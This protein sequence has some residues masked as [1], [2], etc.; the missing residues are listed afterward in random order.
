MLQQ[1]QFGPFHLSY[2]SE[3]DSVILKDREEAFSCFGSDQ[4]AVLPGDAIAK[5]G[6]RACTALT[7]DQR[8]AVDRSIP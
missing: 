7:R 8:R 1:Y 4:A 6:L 2:A 5:Y 3:G